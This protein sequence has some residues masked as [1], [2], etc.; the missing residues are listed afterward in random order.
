MKILV[1]QKEDGIR[2]VAYKGNK[3]QEAFLYKTFLEDCD[4]AWLDFSELLSTKTNN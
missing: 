4:E 3:K 1:E 2:F